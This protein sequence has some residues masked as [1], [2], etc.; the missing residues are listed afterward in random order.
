MIKTAL[1][2]NKLRGYLSYLSLYSSASPKHPETQPASG[3]VL[4]EV[5]L[6]GLWSSVISFC[7]RLTGCHVWGQAIFWLVDFRLLGVN[8][9]LR[10]HLPSV[11]LRIW[12]IWGSSALWAVYFPTKRPSL[13][14]RWRREDRAQGGF[15]HYSLEA[16][17]AGIFWMI[18]WQLEK[19]LLR[20]SDS[21]SLKGYMSKDKASFASRVCQKLMFNELQ[22]AHK[23]APICTCSHHE[24]L[25]WFLFWSCEGWPS[26]WVWT[27]WPTAEWTDLHYRGTRRAWKVRHLIRGIIPWFLH[28]K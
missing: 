8:C 14:P 19:L 21:G 20:H 22:Q 24:F 2:T 11:T 6:A 4:R 9:G 18:N 17:A 12:G 23:K 10:R 5:Q 28:V 1:P 25:S 26:L 27:V 15:P 13:L 16:P 3:F 7:N